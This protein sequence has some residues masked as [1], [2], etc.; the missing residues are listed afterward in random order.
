MKLTFLGTGTSTGVPQ[1]RCTCPVCTSLDP[2]DNRLRCSAMIET[3][4]KRILID[5]GPDFREQMLRFQRPE[6][7][8]DALL[9]TH[10][11]YD[12]TGGIDDLR[13]YYG[14]HAQGFPIYCSADV[15]SDLTTRLPYC[16]PARHY[17]G[18]PILN[19]NV[20]KASQPFTIGD[21]ES[22][23]SITVRPLK[24][25]HGNL[26]ILG[27]RIGGLTYITDCKTLP[28]ESLEAI[29]DK[30]DT[31]VINALFDNRT[32]NRE[33]PTHMNLT[34]AL[35]LVAKIRPRQ[36]YLIHMGHR[37]GIHSEIV[38]TL[39][40]SVTL[41]YDGLTVTIPDL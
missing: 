29:A 10:S 34:Q 27:F 28:E 24:V 31:L 21:S 12:H 5:C 18:A 36:T 8:I 17:P 22:S 9:V 37:I 30:T 16:F 20:I 6:D 7:G 4:G 2:K 15:A 35:D 38:P 41:A 1:I 23:Q 13:P 3:H 26:P 40:S 39:P 25:M 11:H 14:D 33:H 19:L 32:L